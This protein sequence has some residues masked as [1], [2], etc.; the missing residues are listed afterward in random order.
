MEDI[1]IVKKN[2]ALLE[3]EGD[4]YDA[5]ALKEKVNPITFPFFSFHML[6]LSRLIFLGVLLG[7]KIIRHFSPIEKIRKAQ[8]EIRQILGVNI[9]IV[10]NKPFYNTVQLENLKKIGREMFRIEKKHLS[11]F[12]QQENSS[13][14]TYLFNLKKILQFCELYFI[15]EVFLNKKEIET[16]FFGAHLEVYQE[17]P[18]RNIFTLFS[19]DEVLLVLNKQDLSKLIQELETV[20]F[21]RNQIIELGEQIQDIP[22][23][24]ALVQL[25]NDKDLETFKKVVHQRLSL[26]LNEASVYKDRTYGKVFEKIY[27]NEDQ[28]GI[29]SYNK[30]RSLRRKS[31]MNFYDYLKVKDYDQLLEKGKNSVRE[32]KIL[33]LAAL[34]LY[35]CNQ[36]SETVDCMDESKSFFDTIYEDWKTGNYKKSDLYQEQKKA[37]NKINRRTAAIT[38]AIIGTLFQLIVATSFSI[39][40]IQESILHMQECINSREIWD[41]LTMPYEYYWKI[42]KSLIENFLGTLKERNIFTKGRNISI[43]GDSSSNTK[44]QDKVVGH[45]FPKNEEEETELPKYYATGYSNKATYKKG[46]MEFELVQPTI[47]FKEFQDVP[48]EFQVMYCVNQEELKKMVVNRELEL[49]KNLYPVGDNY[50][51]SKITI[52]DSSDSSKKVTIDSQRASQWEGVITPQEKELLFSMHSPKII[53]SYGMSSTPTNPFIDVLEEKPSY[54]TLSLDKRKEAVI[55]GLGLSNDASLEEILKAIQEKDYSKTPIRDAG[56][57]FKIKRLTE[58]EYIETVA[59]LDTLI[60]NL[61]AFLAVEASDE[62][63]YVVGYAYQV[64]DS[65]RIVSGN[66]HAWTMKED[67]QI[68]DVTPSTL[69]KKEES[70]FEEQ[71]DKIILFALQYKIP[72]A[73]AMFLIGAALHKRYGKKVKVSLKAEQVKKILE[74]EDIGNTYAQIQEV[75]YGGGNCA[76][77][78]DVEG[79]ITTIENEFYSFDVQDLK[80]LKQ[81]LQEKIEDGE[82]RR[83]AENLLAM[84]PY[85]KENASDLQKRLILKKK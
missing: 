85:I 73:T 48:V 24:N 74:K 32:K 67:G 71:L 76:K 75:L 16:L 6:L 79:W 52:C 19:G 72:M 54:S 21:D 14:E 64:E 39:G 84:I 12:Y 11:I 77:K 70:Q 63:T 31:Q 53:C 4:L 23:Q 69:S 36:K 7:E 33:S 26:Y 46:K 27:V 83:K 47:S 80:E 45:I 62:L 51:I 18:L 20:K 44:E 61:A 9:D 29:L 2:L 82:E 13:K 22:I 28:I 81:G 50:V 66:A 1:E 56:L 41:M 8:Q 58:E 55:R 5:I 10:R 15:E 17:E 60:C 38:L 43:T 40:F 59:S 34:H 25:M 3:K 68:I 78:Q 35:L 49:V 65:H 57:S 42:E 37:K 30:E